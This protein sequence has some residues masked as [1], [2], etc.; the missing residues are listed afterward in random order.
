M[1][2][3]RNWFGGFLANLDKNRSAS[4]YFC[5]GGFEINCETTTWPYLA[6]IHDRRAKYRRLREWYVEAWLVFRLMLCVN[7]HSET[8]ADKGLNTEHF[9]NSISAFRPC[10]VYGTCV[11]SFDVVCFAFTA[12]HTSLLNL[13]PYIQKMSMLG[14][15][16][17]NPPPLMTKSYRITHFAFLLFCLTRSLSYKPHIY[18]RFACCLG[19]S[20][21]S[22][23]LIILARA[24]WCGSN[25]AET[26]LYLQ[27]DRTTSS[28]FHF[29]TKGVLDITEKQGSIN[30]VDLMCLNVFVDTP[31][32]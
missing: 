18:P 20:I 26:G 25:K 9:A 8:A 23:G 3:V 16:L 30:K 24:R 5:Y 11:I 32:V 4:P 7:Q 28:C 12:S 6:L 10:S 29:N 19:T 31:F 13:K 22:M 17:V 15:A 1:H 21:F 14:N 27:D 2:T